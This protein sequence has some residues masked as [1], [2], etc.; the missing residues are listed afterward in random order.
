MKKSIIKHLLLVCIMILSVAARAA[1]DNIVN[2]GSVEGK[3]A[4]SWSCGWG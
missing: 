1:A 4:T 3:R 2:I